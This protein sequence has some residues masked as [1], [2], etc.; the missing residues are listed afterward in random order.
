MLRRTMLSAEALEPRVV[1][2]GISV[3]SPSLVESVQAEI[4]EVS[5][6]A[7]TDL[8]TVAVPVISHGN[9]GTFD[10]QDFYRFELAAD[11]GI[12]V[13]LDEL[14]RNVDLYLYD[15]SGRRIG[16]SKS[17]SRQHE[18]IVDK[19][20]AGEF[21]VEVRGYR[22]N[23]SDYR[24]IV[25]SQAA[26]DDMSSP[27]TYDVATKDGPPDDCSAT[28]VNDKNDFLSGARSRLA[29][30]VRTVKAEGPQTEPPP[31]KAAAAGTRPLAFPG[32]EGMGA[33][34]QGGQGGDVYVVTNLQD[35]GEGSLRHGID[36]ADGPRT[37]VFKVSGDI[38]LQ[39]RLRIDKPYLT[40]TGQSAPGEGITITGQTVLISNT[41][42]VVMRY[43]RIRPGDENPIAPD[44]HDSLTVAHS[45]DIMLD[46]L[47]LSWAIDEVFN[48]ADVDNVTLQWSIVSEPLVDSLSTWGALGYNALSYRSSISMHHNLFAH[49]SFRMPRVTDGSSFDITNN[50]IYNWS[51]SM[52]ISVGTSTRI[53]AP[54]QGNIENN[55]FVAGPSIGNFDPHRVFWGKD[56]SEVYFEGNILDADLNG[57]FNPEH[58][59]EFSPN[60]LATFVTERFGFSNLTIESAEDAYESV[61]DSAGASAS[62]DATDRRIVLDVINQ[63]GH[64]I[65]SPADVER[66]VSD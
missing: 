33:Y 18:Q 38:E 56:A 46:H 6:A 3:C 28:E 31:P 40:I 39:S 26:N 13:Q 65:D 45:H 8:G 52:P 5:R 19:L 30:R 61:L 50:V 1:L 64:P 4:T 12:D 57:T 59:I 48:T 43:L 62:R 9:V 53:V 41:H 51:R 60:D 10:R 7:A 29:S 21:F 17:A 14:V 20:A 11:G 2:S 27:T 35:S 44:T 54:S 58:D 22:Y 32:A 23:S 25:A 47:S 63:T 15:H 16:Q 49:G 34:A 66:P 24:L 42:D 37:I 36:S 55:V